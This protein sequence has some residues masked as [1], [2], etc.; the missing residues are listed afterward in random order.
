MDGLKRQIRRLLLANV[1]DGH[2]RLLGEDYCYVQ[3]SPDTY[4]FQFWWD[5]CFHVI[6]LCHLGEHALARRNLESLFTMQEDNGFVGH[7]VFW[8]KSLPTHLA[9]V[10][11]ARPSPHAIRPHMSAL[12]QPPLIATA[13]EH[14]QKRS[15]DTLFTHEMLPRLIRY[16]EWLARERDFDGSGLLT[17]ISPFES[18]LDFKPSYDEMLGYREGK[19]GAGLLWRAMRVDAGNF[20]RRY[21][22]SRI[23]RAGRFK[24]KDVL[25]NTFYALD[26]LA[27]SRLCDDAGFAGPATLYRERAGRVCAAIL[28]EMW[29]PGLAAFLD[30]D[31][32]GRRI[33]VLT[34]TLFVPLMLPGLP[35]D[36]ARLVVA[37]HLHDPDE[38]ALRYP[39][40]SAAAN[41]AAFNP[42]E[43]GRFLWRGPTW[44]VGNWCLWHG[45]K[46]QG[47]AAE[48]AKVAESMRELITHSGFREYYDPNTGAGQGARDFT[49]SGLV[50]DMR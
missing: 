35:A 41:S 22:L 36:I 37:R 39:V 44:A 11:Q 43:G 31:G 24:V 45:L 2:S 3:P 21:D 12:I 8:K 40:P 6:M 13:L 32:E 28:S 1:S 49:W 42:G 50:L 26:L 15:Q 38:F 20:L 4:P 9:D 48:A 14:F 47:L 10:L 30:L 33:P 25:V 7:M 46:R 34:F 16:F 23:R 27:L 19:A 29:D 5:T 17:T 18:G